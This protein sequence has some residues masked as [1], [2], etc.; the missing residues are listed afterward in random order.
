MVEAAPVITVC[1]GVASNSSGCG[2]IASGKLCV[3]FGELGRPCLPAITASTAASR[4]SERQR[5][6]R[7]CECGVGPDHPY[8]RGYEGVVRILLPK[9]V[10]GALSADAFHERSPRRIQTEAMRRAAAAA[11]QSSSSTIRPETRSLMRRS[12]SWRRIRPS[13][14]LGRPWHWRCW[15]SCAGSPLNRSIPRFR[16]GERSPAK[17]RLWLA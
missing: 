5:G 9:F 6:R 12:R 13:H 3:R 16:P 14:Q 15:R 2:R 17:G 8:P 10:S 7:R 11:R 1:N 4:P